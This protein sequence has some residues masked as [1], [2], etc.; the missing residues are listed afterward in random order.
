M[1]G[2]CNLRSPNWN[3]LIGEIFFDSWTLGFRLF[4]HLGKFIFF[5]L[6]RHRFCA[7]SA[8][9]YWPFARVVAPQMPPLHLG[10]AELFWCL[11]HLSHL[12]LKGWSIENTRRIA[13]WKSFGF[14]LVAEVE[15]M[16][17]AKLWRYSVYMQ[18]DLTFIECHPWAAGDEQSRK[19]YAFWVN[20][21]FLKAPTV[22]AWTN[23]SWFEFDWTWIKKH[24]PRAMLEYLDSQS[25]LA[26][27]AVD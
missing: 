23:N 7:R 10:K 17:S 25:K 18:L 3:W 9:A 11:S 16:P 19:A 2:A 21:A 1:Y 20:C 12:S 4:F 22:L 24:S 8:T 26:I 13:W 15:M 27:P 6:L 14:S 5:R